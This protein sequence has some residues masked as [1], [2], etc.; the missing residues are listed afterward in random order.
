MYMSVS[1]CAFVVMNKVPILAR[2]GS[3]TP[4]VLEF[5]GHCEQPNMGAGGPN[6]LWE[7]SMCVYSLTE[8][9]LQLSCFLFIF[10]K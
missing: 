10:K 2:K 4:L 9:A 8:P 3:W 1:M 7:R 6:S 5:K